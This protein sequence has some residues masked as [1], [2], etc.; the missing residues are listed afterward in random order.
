VSTLAFES[1]LSWEC[2]PFDGQ[3]KYPGPRFW[4]ILRASGNGFLRE[5]FVSLP[6]RTAGRPAIHSGVFRKARKSPIRPRL[7]AEFWHGR[8][9][10][11]DAFRQDLLQRDAR[12]PRRSEV[13]SFRTRAFEIAR[14]LQI[15]GKLGLR[16]TLPSPPLGEY[17]PPASAYS[18]MG[19]LRPLCFGSLA[20]GDSSD[21]NS[22]RAGIV[23]GG[24]VASGDGSYLPLLRAPESERYSSVFR[25]ARK[26]PIWSGSKRNCGMVGWPTTMP[27]AR[28]SCSVSTG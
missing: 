22:A 11:D 17:G 26:S 12:K 6:R 5:A 16:L 23:T 9:A 14:R 24:K 18:T 1:G 8:M 4:L 15:W 10:D 19:M 21:K 25:N 27:S 28:A 13:P 3:Q 7:E 2:P 20:A